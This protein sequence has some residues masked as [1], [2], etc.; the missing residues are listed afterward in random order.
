MGQYVVRGVPASVLQ[1]SWW[2]DEPEKSPDRSDGTT[3][4]NKK[5]AGGGLALLVAL[6]DVLFLDYAPGISLAVFALVVAGIVWVLL[7]RRSGPFGPALLL[8]LSVLPVVEYVQAL[9]IAFLIGG[10]IVALCWAVLGSRHDLGAT[11]RRFM[12]LLPILAIWQLIDTLRSGQALPDKDRIGLQFL[13]AWAFPFGG[14]LV[15][16][17]LMVSANPVLSEWVDGLWSFDIRF[18]RVLFWIGT[19]IMIWPVL[20]VA[21]QPGI[22]SPKSGPAKQRKLPAI[23]LNAQS[24]ANALILFNLMLAVQTVMDAFFLWGNVELP[25]GMSHAEYAHRG[26]YP[27]L[28]TAL[29]AGAFALAARPYLTERKGLTGWMMLWLGQ[30][31]LLVISSILR[32]SIYVQEYGLT[33]LRIYAAIWMGL[34]AAGLCLT[35]WQILRGRSNRWLLLRSAA[36]GLGVLYSCSFV[37]FAAVIARE[38]LRHTER[39]DEYYVCQLGPMA[40]AEI[41]ASPRPTGCAIYPPH[42]ANWREWGFRADRVS[43]SLNAELGPETGYENPRRG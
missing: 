19:A 1:D 38:N 20:A 18:E 15:L 39:Y 43:R 29:L 11:V 12:G 4:P 33:Y 13:R 16:A 26:A 25:D 37:N 32:L 30:N 40:S 7:G 17:S 2:L 42:I 27:L 8:I 10:S 35:A 21:S 36:L 5:L 41:A 28:V 14:A 6:A 24:V 23:G 34:V 9:S 3:S 31:V 22:L